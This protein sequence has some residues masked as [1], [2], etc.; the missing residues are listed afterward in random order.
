MSNAEPPKES[1]AALFEREGAVPTGR[2]L[3]VG[4]AVRGPVVQAHQGTVIVD[5]DGKQQ[6]FLELL[7]LPA[8]ALPAVG[9]TVDAFVASLEGGEI[10]LTKSLPKTNAEATFE[11][12][13]AALEREQPVEGKVVGGN[14]G[15]LAVEIGGLRCFCPSSQID[16]RFVEDKA[17]FLQQT[18]SFL[19]TELRGERDV[20]LSR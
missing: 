9:D 11:S 8:S 17:Q 16:L 15:G 12:L 5:L 14:T 3:S 4:D 2:R 10:R 13:R 19:V 7:D 20:V 1:F 6:G 18:L